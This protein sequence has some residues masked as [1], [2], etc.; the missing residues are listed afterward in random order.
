LRRVDNEVKHPK[1]GRIVEPQYLVASLGTP[2]PPIPKQGDQRTALVDWLTSKENPFF[3]RAIVNRVWS[4]FFGRGIIEPVDDIRASN[5][6]VNEPLLN[7]L[8]KD[9]TDHGF[10]LKY[11]MKTIANSRTYQASIRSN[12]WNTDDLINFSH[13]IPRRLSAEQLADA[14]STATGSKFKFPDV[15][16]GF[17]AVE[18]P[19]PHV[20]TSGFLDLFGRPQREEPCECERRSDMSLP[21]A[22]NL[23]NGPTLAN[24][25]ADPEGR[26][27]K[28]ILKGAPD[29][30]LIEE[31]YLG[32]LNRLPTPKEYGLAAAHLKKSSGRTAAA[33]DILWAMLNQ[34]AF[35]FNR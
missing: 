9:F 33:Q 31:L 30:E 5:P 27:A 8:A 4:Y 14:I 13:Q 12:D 17:R 3:A 29:R 1:D 10:D 15:P 21:H 20:E 22:L 32:G 2:P 18:L 23:V 28:L 7:A 11:L 6:P 25:I 16:E 26:V 19:D 34:K 24:A 35:L